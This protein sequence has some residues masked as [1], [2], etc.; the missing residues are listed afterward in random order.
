MKKLLSTFLISLFFV[1]FV[2]ATEWNISSDAFKSLGSIVQDTTVEGLTINASADKAVV[3]DENAK[4]L[5][6]ISFTHRLKLGGAGTYIDSV[7]SDRVISFK[8]VGD[9]KIT[10]AAMSSTGS[11]NRL[12]NIVSANGDTLA[13]FP[14]LGDSLLLQNTSMKAI[15]L[16]S[17]YSLPVVVSIF[18]H[19]KLKLLKNLLLALSLVF[20]KMLTV[21]LIQRL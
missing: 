19:L 4:T 8:V 20:Q 3:V 1:G 5:G 9:T 21:S 16:Q 7:A 15:L 17:I 2:N 18:I 13:Q 14:A 10:V 11:E 6:D 12:L